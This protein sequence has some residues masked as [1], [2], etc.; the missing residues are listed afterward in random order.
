MMQQYCL[1]LPSIASRAAS[2]ENIGKKY[3]DLAPEGKCVKLARRHMKKI[4]AVHTRG[5]SEDE[6]IALILYTMEAVPR[7]ESLYYLMSAALRGKKA[8]NKSQV[9]Q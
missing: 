5:M 4:D 3:P 2:L 6:I 9:G 1:P 8:R 7:E